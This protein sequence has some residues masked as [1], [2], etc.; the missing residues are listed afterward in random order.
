MKLYLVRHGE[1]IHPAVDQT[2]PL[3]PQG[4][5]N[6]EK[7][8]RYLNAQGANL[9]SIFHSGLTRAA[10]S[11]QIL[12]KVLASNVSVQQLAGLKPN[13]PVENILP[14]A[15]EWQTD[16]MLVGH[17]PFMGLFTDLLL[18]GNTD[19]PGVSFAEGS[20]ACLERKQSAWALVRVSHA[21][22]RV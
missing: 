22:E 11:A 17:L 15:S 12:A 18:C 8:G 19:G 3:S 2:C 9:Q 14:L 6:I 10:Q 4:Q 20:C 13:D 5:A 16:T 1:Y 21:A 7:L